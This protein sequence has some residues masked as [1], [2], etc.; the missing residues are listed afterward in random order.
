MLQDILSIA[1]GNPNA[2]IKDLK[3]FAK[4][5]NMNELSRP[6]KFLQFDNSGNKAEIEFAETNYGKAILRINDDIKKPK[7]FLLNII[8]KEILRITMMS[9]KPKTFLLNIRNKEILGIESQ[10]NSTNTLNKKP[11]MQ[12]SRFF[13]SMWKILKS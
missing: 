13:I 8:S 6:L 7:P 5:L 3:V 1:K 10:N 12:Y 2:E 11:R 9:K 4:D